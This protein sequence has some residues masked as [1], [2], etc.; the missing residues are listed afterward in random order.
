[1]GN[2]YIVVLRMLRTVGRDVN[3]EL[4]QPA[5]NIVLFGRKGYVRGFT[6][7]ARYI[8]PVRRIDQMQEHGDLRYTIAPAINSA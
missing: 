3:G 4:H 8:I 2:Y 5:T 1:M 7:L 6:A